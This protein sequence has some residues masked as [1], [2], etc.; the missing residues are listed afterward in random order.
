M[1]WYRVSWR[2]LAVGCLGLVGS[3]A[4][5][6]KPAGPGPVSPSAAA[7]ETTE[8]VSA[9]LLAQGVGGTAEE[10]EANARERLAADLLGD[11]R[12][13]ALYPIE[14]HNS[15]QDAGPVVEQAD[16]Q[17][18]V[19]LGLSRARAAAVISE[20]E[21]GRPTLSG[22]DAWRETLYAVISARAAAHV[23][24]RRRALF[25]AQ[26][27][28]GDLSESEA[29]LHALAT[30][31]RLVAEYQD[32]VP[33]DAEGKV[34]RMPAVFVL[35]NGVPAAEVPLSTKPGGAQL[36]DAA[37]RVPVDIATGAAMPTDAVV[38]VDAGKVLGPLAAAWPEAPLHL[39]AR[40]LTLSRWTLASL[41]NGSGGPLVKALRAALADSG[42]GA[43]ATSSPKP[44]E[45]A[46]RGPAGRRAS[47]LAAAAHEARG[48][49]DYVFA[50]NVSSTFSSRM[51]GNRVWFQA[52]GSVE[53]FD[54]WT[55]E[56]ILALE[57]K[58]RGAGVG[59]DAADQ[60][61]RAKL[62]ATLTAGL[63]A[64]AGQRWPRK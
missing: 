17:V 34:L 22:P 26:C 24:R 28:T 21:M 10:A 25:A 8:G 41:G 42:L 37:G 55:G 52:V 15:Q 45:A 62:V 64:Q 16:G 4:C 63:R 14:I 56:K 19:T 9:W 59:D 3:V 33:V 27:E 18:S 1:S 44:F 43:Q 20:F 29:E 38:Q 2:Q 60:A 50:A 57:A 13:L 12:W 11:P 30:S 49:V 32:G 58:E 53:V 6:P 36:S 5:E 46:A 61:A 23:C 39:L 54:A 51:G 47:A 35:W 7:S 31:V 40:P 48:A